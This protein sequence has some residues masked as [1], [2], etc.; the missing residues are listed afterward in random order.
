MIKF[1]SSLKLNEIHEV[2][3]LFN[4]DPKNI[5]FSREVLISGEGWWENLGKMSNNRDIYRYANRGVVNFEREYQPLPPG[6]KIFVMPLFSH[7]PDQI[8]GK[9]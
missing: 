1:S 5:T 9:K 7:M 3:S 8:L 6:T 4:E 2:D